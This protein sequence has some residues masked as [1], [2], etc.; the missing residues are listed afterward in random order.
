MLRRFGLRH[1]SPA[2]LW[3]VEGSAGAGGFEFMGTW[4]NAGPP[5]TGSPIRTALRPDPLAA[6]RARS[7]TSRRSRR[8][9]PPSGITAHPT[10]TLNPPTLSGPSGVGIST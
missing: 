4:R 3:R 5:D 9:A 10:D 1:Q 2:L 8:S 7:A 6:Y